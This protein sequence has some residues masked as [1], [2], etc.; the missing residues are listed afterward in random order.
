VTSE[1]IG[2]SANQRYTQHERLVAISR[3]AVLAMLFFTPWR[4]EWPIAI[5]GLDVASLPNVANVPKLRPADVLAIAAIITFAL[6]GWPNLKRLWAPKLRVWAAS[7]VMLTVW[8]ASSIAWANQRTLA[9]AFT[10]HLMLWVFVA[11]RLA[12]DDVPPRSIALSL[13][14]GLMLNAVIG[15][16]QFAAQ[17]H[18]GLSALGELPIELTYPNV[19][20][21]GAGGIHLIRLYGL[22]GHP[23]VIG[24]YAAIA[25][26]MSAGL[27]AQRR[28]TI[29]AAWSIGLIALLLT[30][31]RSAWLALAIGVSVI[32]LG[33]FLAN[34]IRIQAWWIGPALIVG[35]WAVAFAPYLIERLTASHLTIEQASIGERIAQA[36]TALALI[37]AHPIAGVGVGNFT[38]AAQGAGT[39][40]VDPAPPVDWVHNVPLLIASELGV[41]G[42]GAWLIGVG[43]VMRSGLAQPADRG[44]RSAG[45]A[46]LAAM[47]I[48]ML[49][50]HYL[51]TSSQGVY[52]WA[53]I[54][55]WWMSRFVD[56]PRRF[57]LCQPDGDSFTPTING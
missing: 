30:F 1:G 41:I 48:I 38:V 57:R 20:V 10:V 32:M 9:L 50:D 44:W 12:C 16:G 17:H 36:D 5:S 18:L 45:F 43:A 6:A 55:G 28:A 56:C 42:F 33:S 23:N 8:A 21:V 49:F 52:L 27:L 22:S 11:L 46:A 53:A 54:T 26:L 40:R 14:A 24:G 51:W 2:E 34:R 29:G 3:W 4:L 25:L 19:S 39:V 47:L 35:V 31:S 7:L 15:F 37:A 13:L